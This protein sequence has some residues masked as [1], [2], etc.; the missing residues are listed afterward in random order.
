MRKFGS[1]ITVALMVATLI[2]AAKKFQLTA[3]SIVPA[4]SGFVEIGKDHNGNTE[5]QLRVKNLARPENLTPSQ[6]SYVIWLQAKDSPPENEGELKVN[7]KLEGAFRTVTPR[8]NFDLFVTGEND[9]KVKEPS[10]PEV[11]RTTIS[12]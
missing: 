4:A 1:M 2:Y 9:A 6:A 3:S 5:V 8:K 10:G 12:R 7:G 11:L